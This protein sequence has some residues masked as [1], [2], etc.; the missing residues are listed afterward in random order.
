M[1]IVFDEPNEKQKQRIQEVAW[2]WL[3]LDLDDEE[4]EVYFEKLCANNYKIPDDEGG[5]FCWES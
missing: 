1:K 4:Y 3:R 2:K 5:P